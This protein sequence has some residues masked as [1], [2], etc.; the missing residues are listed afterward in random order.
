[1]EQS[2]LHND[3]AAFITTSKASDYRHQ[4]GGGEGGYFGDSVLSSIIASTSTTSTPY[5][6]RQ[7]SLFIDKRISLPMSTQP[8][9]QMRKRVLSKKE[10]ELD[11]HQVEWEDDADYIVTNA[12]YDDEFSQ[13]EDTDFDNEDIDLPYPG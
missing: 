13:D 9:N 7:S 4:G 8:N 5:H 1:M 11:K 10:C 3:F 2:W 12:N 6:K